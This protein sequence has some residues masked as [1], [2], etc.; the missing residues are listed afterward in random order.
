[1]TVIE[2]IDKLS[3]YPNYWK[4]QLATLGP[5]GREYYDIAEVDVDPLAA[6]YGSLIIL[7]S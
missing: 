4:V 2:L 3:N 7:K 6:E 1:V 5:E